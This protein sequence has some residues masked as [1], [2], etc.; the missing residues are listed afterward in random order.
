MADFFGTLMRFFQPI[1]VVCPVCTMDNYSRTYDKMLVFTT[2]CLIIM[3]DIS[4]G[5]ALGSST[6]I[7][8]FVVSLFTS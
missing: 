1:E 6:Q 8:M 7:A 2:Y 3:Q 4:I 5:V